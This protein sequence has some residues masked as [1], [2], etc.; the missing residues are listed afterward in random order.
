MAKS[1]IA[2]DKELPEIPG[3]CPW[4]RP[5]SFLVKDDKAPDGWRVDESGRRPSTLLLIK[6][7]RAA[8]DRWRKQGYPGASEV[9]QRLFEYW[10]EEDHDIAGF[11]VPFRYHFCQREAIETLAYLVEVAGNRDAKQLIDAYAQVFQKDLYTQSIEDQTTMEGKRQIRRYV[12]EL[13]G[14]GVQDLPPENLRRYAFKMATGSGKTWVIAMAIVWSHFHKKKVKGSDLSTNFLIVAPNV[15]VYQRLERDFASNRI[16]N[17]LP[18]IPPEWQ[19]SQ[20]VILRGD[21]AEPEP[22]GNLFLTNIH[23]LYE[24]RD[25]DWTPQNAIDA[26]LGKKPNKDLASYQRSMLER[27]QDLTDLV[28]INDEAHHVHD[29]ELAWSKSLL[30]L[31]I[32]VLRI[33]PRSTGWLTLRRHYRIRCPG[34]RCRPSR[35]VESV[36]C[37][38]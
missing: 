10:F 19:W 28:A 24:S 34:E 5:T 22:S 7:L 27:L 20:K 25:Q 37:R 4:E 13:D 21:S 32:R 36:L 1:V 35:G 31:S 38:S 33:A 8:V 18:L 15:I 9:T 2:Y 14:E 11:P 17:W 23:Q 26:L 16:F 29:E 12:P 3:R 30:S 6:K